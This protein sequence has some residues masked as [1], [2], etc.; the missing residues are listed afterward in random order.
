MDAYL[1]AVDAIDPDLVEGFYVIGSAAL[2]DFRP[3]ASDV[4][5][6]AVTTQGVE[7]S[8]EGPLSAA[9]EDHQNGHKSQRV[10]LNPKFRA[11]G[12]RGRGVAA[13]R[14]WGTHFASLSSAQV[15]HRYLGLL[16][17]AIYAP[18]SRS[19]IHA[20]IAGRS[21]SP[22]VTFDSD[23]DS[24]TLVFSGYNTPQPLPSTS[25]IF[26]LPTPNYA[27]VATQA[28][29][30]RTILTVTLTHNRGRGWFDRSGGDSHGGGRNDW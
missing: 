22:S 11:P 16:R 19:L 25:K 12:N 1:L 21:Y 24:A 14:G 29:D 27:P 26:G 6:V 17:L 10:T 3:G 28:D 30:Y 23:H 18:Q 2:D 7:E 20:P 8:T 4:D 9:P 15:E 13:S 5:F